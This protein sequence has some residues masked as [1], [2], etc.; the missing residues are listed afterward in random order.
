MDTGL[1]NKALSIEFKSLSS[2]WASYLALAAA[3]ASG[4][5]FPF[6]SFGLFPFAPFGL[7]P[8]APFPSAPL[9]L[10]TPF[11]LFPF[12]SLPLA[13]FKLAR[14]LFA[15]SAFAYNINYWNL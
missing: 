6:V 1:F 3:A 11:W 12:K 7:F 2:F 5:K 4:S 13:P 8:F 14:L 15:S 10:F 9:L